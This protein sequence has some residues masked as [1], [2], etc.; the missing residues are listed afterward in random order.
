MTASSN[1]GNITITESSAIRLD[2]IEAT[3]G[4]IWIQSSGHM[5]ANLVDSST[6]DDI[7]NSITLTSTGG[8]LEVRSI[9]AGPNAPVSLNAQSGS[10]SQDW[11]PG[12]TAGGSETFASA[13][14]APT[15]TNNDLVVTSSVPGPGFND[16][17]IRF[18]AGATGGL[19]H[20]SFDDQDTD[21]PGHNRF[22]N[23]H[24][25]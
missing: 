7:S 14:I 2:S 20:A 23:G 16:V 13:V 6:T 11:E 12:V 25:H 19:A 18:E 22:G 4:A 1:N 24:R 9:D 17:T 5:V 8:G 15:G 21:P 10:I 3:D